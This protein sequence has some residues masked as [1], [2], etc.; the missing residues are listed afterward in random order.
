LKKL[1]IIGFVFPEP[2]SSAAGNRMMQLI[3]LFQSFG[4]S[5]YFGTTAQNIDFSENLTESGV[6]LVSIELN[7]S[8]FDTLLGA[9]QPTVVLFD[10]FMIEE[11]YGWRVAQQCPNA[12][13][14]LD[15]E[16]LHCLRYARMQAVKEGRDF[17]E[18]DLIS[19]VSKREIASILRCDISLMVSTF[20]MDLLVSF[21]KVPKEILF[22][23]PIF[24]KQLP[25]LPAFDD[26]SDFVFIGNFLHE[27][28]WD[29]VRYLAASIWPKIHAVLPEVRMRV[30]GAYPSQKV[31]E[32]HKP[33]LHFYVEG[34]AQDALQ[35]IMNSRVM[36]A[37]LRFGAG[38][39]GKLIESMQ[40]G[41]PNITT[42]IGAESM[43][44]GLT[45][46]GFIKEDADDF[47]DAAIRLYQEEAVWNR[48]QQNGFE[49]LEAKYQRAPYVTLF[50]SY[51]FAIS[52]DL[53][54]HRAKNFIGLML[55]HHSLASTKY[56]SK[57]IEEKNTK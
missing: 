26:R 4:Y 11:Q 46:N 33:A 39:K 24:A 27:P 19:S 7:S 34:R 5:I 47:A 52:N 44:D 32:L 57:W 1:L 28:N 49:L 35:V 15:T 14:I 55:L 53:H 50:E 17:R 25:N 23:L 37:P 6:Q 43:S 41:T 42:S 10:R 29:A 16:D 22:Y 3:E 54:S 18:I 48:C 21:F 12:I 56:M 8:S 36:L 20:E 13:R 31:L 30:Y 2:Q 45:W 40:C 51:F 9:I 38:I